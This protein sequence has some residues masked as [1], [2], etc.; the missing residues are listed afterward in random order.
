MKK[1]SLIEFCSKLGVSE[2]DLNGLIVED[3]GKD[4]FRLI[5]I[6]DSD[7]IA[8]ISKKQIALIAGQRRKNLIR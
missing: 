4:F 7:K 2:K 1:I 8:E 5:Y 3:N 6:G